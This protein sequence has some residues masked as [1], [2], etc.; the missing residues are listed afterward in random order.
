MKE[1]AS[2]LARSAGA[3][4]A[5]VGPS[6]PPGSEC[7]VRR[8]RRRTRSV[9][10]GCGGCGSEPRNDLLAGAETVFMVERNMSNAV[11]RGTRLVPPGSRAA[12]RA[13]GARRNLGYLVSGRHLL[14]PTVRIG[15][16]RSR[17]R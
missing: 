7:C 15:K 16:A 3:S 8:R 12:S 13:Q 5:Q 17:S 9:H 11:M 14:T 6:K 2:K 4:P 10:S 1:G